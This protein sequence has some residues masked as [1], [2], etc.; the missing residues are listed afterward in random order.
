MDGKLFV[1]DDKKAMC[2]LVRDG[3]EPLGLEVVWENDPHV[4]INE[5]RRI[6]PDVV[7]ADIRM[8]EMTGIELCAR[9]HQ[10]AP[11]VPVIVMTGFGTLELAVE[12]IRAGAYDF[13]SK[14][15]E[16]DVL[17]FSVGRALEHAQLT[18]EISRLNQT[19]DNLQPVGAGHRLEGE[20]PPMLRLLDLIPKTATSDVS[21]LIEGETGTGKELLARDLHDHSLRKN[22]PF[23]AINCAAL[24][25]SLAESELFG[26]AKGAYTD[27]KNSRKGLFVQAN[28][29]TLFLDEIGELPKSLQ[30]KLLRA[31]QDSTFRPVG[32][33]HEVKVDCRVIAAT[34]RDLKSEAKEGH[35][36]PDLYYRLA[37]IKI[38]MPSLRE[39]QGDILNLAQ[40]FKEKVAKRLKMVPPDFSKGMASKLLAYSWPGNVRELEN[41]IERAVALSDGKVIAIEDL[42]EELWNSTL[43]IPDIVNN[44]LITMA[45]L[46]EKHIRHVLKSV[47]GNKKAAAKILGLD[48]RTLYR[49]LETYGSR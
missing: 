43:K 14:P 48:R 11:R 24:P 27:A 15:I 45:D 7:L 1:I 9:I 36:R 13:L 37:V 34:N 32:S 38:K 29:G 44:G 47:A 6:D 39:R 2:E 20:S 42:P 28:G 18:A 22:G 17:E 12:A 41:T 10:I 46:E 19:I 5:F 40:I 16:L 30:P 21:V 33:D 23:I 49:K 8:P 4:A 31:L 25:E 35:F 26:H 3:L